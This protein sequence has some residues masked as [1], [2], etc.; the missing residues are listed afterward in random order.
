MGYGTHHVPAGTWSDDTSMAIATLDSLASGIDY[1]DIMS[2]FRT[3]KVEVAYTATDEVF[4]MGVSTNTAISRFQK[5][6][7]ALECGCS[8]ENDNGNGSLMRIYPA[9]LYW[10]F[11]N[12]G[13]FSTEGFDEFIFD[14]SALTHAH[15]RSKLAC[16]IYAYALLHL[17]ERRTKRVFV[18]DCT[19]HRWYIQK[20]LL[21]LLS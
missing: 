12:N 3:W 17:L 13:K 20:Y 19:M 10:Y 2:K 16:G 11:T 9:V 21:M 5:G 1:D 8:G 4:D 7:P 14:I 18:M 15:L 6:M